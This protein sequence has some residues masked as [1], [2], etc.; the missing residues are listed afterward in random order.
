MQVNQPPHVEINV[1][2]LNGI[3][4]LFLIELSPSAEDIDVLVVED[5]TGSRVSSNIEVSYPAP[6]IVLDV[7]LLTSC[8]ETLCI[9]TTDYKDEASL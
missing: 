6:G 7:I 5:A 2:H 9:I 1:V 8:V 3:S 4:N